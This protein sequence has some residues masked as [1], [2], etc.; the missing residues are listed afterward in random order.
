MSPPRLQPVD[1]VRPT[2][3]ATWLCCSAEPGWRRNVPSRPL[4]RNHAV[5]MGSARATAMRLRMATSPDSFPSPRWGA[6]ASRLPWSASR[7]TLLAVDRGVPIGETPTGAAETAALPSQRTTVHGDGL[8]LG[9]F[10]NRMAMR[11]AVPFPSPS[12]ASGDGTN[13]VRYQT[14]ARFVLPA[15]HGRGQRSARAALPCG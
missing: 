4:G 14:F 6:R 15:E 7:R 5:E 8:T 13:R 3:S 9:S 10:L 11:R 12:A 1:T 2:A